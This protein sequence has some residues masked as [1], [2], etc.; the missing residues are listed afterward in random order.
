MRGGSPNMSRAPI[1]SPPPAAPARSCSPS[2]R[3]CC[4]TRSRRST[5]RASRRSS[6]TPDPGAIGAL[7]DLLKD[8]TNPVAIVG[9][10]DWSPCAGASLRQ[11]RGPPRHPHRRRLPPPGCGRQRLRR[12]CRPARLWPQS[13][14]AAAHPRR[15]PADRGRRAAGRSRPPT[16]TSSSP[17][18]IP[19][20]YW[21]TST[22]TPTNLAASITPTC[23]SA[24]T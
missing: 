4:A 2:P 11:F 17:P 19:A 13:Q 23:R 20:S 9:G 8:A 1:A 18:T 7:F 10:A 6:E 3:T 21:S 15:R 14:A 24:P 16:A 12:L 5:G 22:P